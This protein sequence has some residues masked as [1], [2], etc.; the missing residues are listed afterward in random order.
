M[1]REPEY[2]LPECYFKHPPAL[3]TSHLSKFSLETLFY[4]FYSMPRDTL[5]VFAAKELYARDWKY[6][7]RLQLWFT[8]PEDAVML[9]LGYQPNSLVY[10]DTEIWE[11][12]VYLSDPSNLVFMSKD[13]VQAI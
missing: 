8:H 11:R 10:F 6:H 2:K 13:E 12:R 9:S 5:Q 4:I 3:K 7:K 1:T